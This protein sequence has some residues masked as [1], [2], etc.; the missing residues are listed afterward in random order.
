MLTRTPDP[1]PQQVLDALPLCS[2]RAGLIQDEIVSR[3]RIALPGA[4]ALWNTREGYDG[5]AQV[6][7]PSAYKP[8]P[9]VLA[10]DWMN[11][12]LVG[13]AVQTQADGIRQFGHVLSITIYSVGDKWAM[14]DVGTM[15]R[16]MERGELIQG[17]LYHFLTCCINGAGV[18]LWNTLAPTGMTGMP[19]GWADDYA[20]VAVTYQLEA[21]GRGV[22][23]PVPS[24]F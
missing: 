4:I 20:G 6:K 8:A 18:Q 24:N 21:Y 17:V 16:V 7:P 23:R 9:A 3:L 2:V 5:L 14:G 12:V 22:A 15:R 13:V 11:T 19:E 10:G 1:T